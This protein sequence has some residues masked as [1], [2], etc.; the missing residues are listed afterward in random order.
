MTQQDDVVVFGGAGFIGR[1][2]VHAL[3]PRVRSVTVV[4]RGVVDGH[5]DEEGTRYRRGD[6]MSVETAKR[7]IEGA[8]VVYDLSL[9]L[10]AGWD[11]FHDR[12]TACAA[13][14]AEAVRLHLDGDEAELLGISS[15]PRIILT[16]EILPSGYD[17]ET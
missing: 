5:V 11:D 10:G 3:K 17:A 13:N 8:A 9:P 4:S 7:L 16:Y 1:H 6:L 14:L 12:C 15:K 2:L